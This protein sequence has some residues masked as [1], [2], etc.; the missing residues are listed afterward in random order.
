MLVELIPR[1]KKWLLNCSYNPNNNA[2]KNHLTTLSK[3]LDLY[4]KKYENILVFG[5]FN[6]EFEE[7]NMKTFCNAFG[8]Q[9]LIKQSTCYKN[10]DKPTCI[11]LMLSN[12]PKSFHKSCVI[13]TGLSD[14]HLMTLT[15]MTSKFYK[16]QPRVI[17]YSDYKHFSNEVF[18]RQNL[19]KKMSRCPL[20]QSYKFF[21]DNCF[22]TLN[23]QATKKKKYLRGNNMPFMT[24]ELS[25]AIMHRSKLRKKYLK[26]KNAF[27]KRKYN[28]QRNY[29]VSLLRR[30]K[31]KYFNN[32][33]EKS[34]TDNKLFWKTI[35]PWLSDKIF[36]KDKLI[37]IEN[38]T[39]E[40]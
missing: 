36:S 35:K 14:F 12:V 27:N 34:I 22:E 2:I 13:E 20:N 32:L 37:L 26:Q 24:K 25:K 30:N 28:E 23:E 6:V 4:S 5:D 40:S 11:D 21:M 31:K 3:D 9:S 18:F 8:L 17:E 19:F 33:N 1:K 16:L 15:I 10:P 38:E 29:C 7:V 39:V